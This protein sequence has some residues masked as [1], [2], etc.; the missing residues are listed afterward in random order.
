[1]ARNPLTKEQ[2]VE[3]KRER[4][5]VHEARDKISARGVDT[6]NFYNRYIDITDP[7]NVDRYLGAGY[8][9]VLKDGHTETPAN[10]V[11][12]ADGISSLKTLSGGQGKLMALVRLPIELWL[13]DQNKQEQARRDQEADMRRDLAAKSDPRQGN[14][15]A[16]VV[17]FD[18]RLG[19]NPLKENA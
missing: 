19:A 5:P 9:F 17:E 2:L 3:L 13:E 14:L 18:S 15:G 1:M 10:T 8:Q 7:D 6:V 16:G 12:T 11:D 4:V